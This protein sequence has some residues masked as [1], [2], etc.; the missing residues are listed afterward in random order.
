M[1]HLVRSRVFGGGPGIADLGVR[2]AVE[3]GDLRGV[4]A[5]GGRR[6]LTRLEHRDAGAR[7]LQ[8]ERGGHP[9]DPA[10]DDADVDAP[11][12]GQR[13]MPGARISVVPG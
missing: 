8:D 3:R 13:G 4:V 11:L 5:A 10:A 7:A 6:H 1:P 12:A 2:A 9:D